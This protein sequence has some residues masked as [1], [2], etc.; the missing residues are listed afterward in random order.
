M[1]ITKS[2]NNVTVAST[3]FVLQCWA[4]GL[5]PNSP[6]VKPAK[7]KKHSYIKQILKLA[8]VKHCTKLYK[9]NKAI[10]SWSAGQNSTISWSYTNKQ[11]NRN[12]CRGSWER[13]AGGRDGGMS[14]VVFD[15]WLLKQGVWANAWLQAQQ[16]HKTSSACFNIHTLLHTNPSSFSSSHTFKHTTTLSISDKSSILEQCVSFF[17]KKLKRG[18]NKTCSQ[19]K[20]D[21]QNV[22]GCHNFF[23]FHFYLHLVVSWLHLN[24][25]SYVINYFSPTL[26]QVIYSTSSIS[27]A[28]FIAH[29]DCVQIQPK[30]LNS[31]GEE[32]YQTG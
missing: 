29:S 3:Y 23:Y 10:C 16:P 5:K 22:F 11:P 12:W 8:C 31:R 30:R 15:P 24:S 6:K 7:T 21:R 20:Q 32:H 9:C 2:F 25:S 14:A 28:L 13:R 1:C 18:D 26:L 17:K 27:L 19:K 4:L